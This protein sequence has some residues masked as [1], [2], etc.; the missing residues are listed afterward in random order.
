MIDVVIRILLVSFLFISFSVQGIFE[1]TVYGTEYNSF[2]D[3]KESKFRFTEPNLNFY[4]I[5]VISLI[6][7]GIMI[8]SKQMKTKLFSFKDKF[9]LG[10][11]YTLGKYGSEN[12]YN[13]LDYITKNI[14]K[15]CKTLTSK[16]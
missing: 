11:L 1:E 8:M 3:D 6:V 10:F 14:A 2:A 16:L 12:S 13:Y 7:S 9:I 15:S 4:T 5:A